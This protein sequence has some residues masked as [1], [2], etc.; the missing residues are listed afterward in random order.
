MITNIKIKYSINHFLFSE[1]LRRKKKIMYISSD[2]LLLIFSIASFVS[3][4][5][6]VIIFSFTTNAL[7]YVGFALLFIAVVLILI[8]IYR[9][10]K[11]KHKKNGMI[12]GV[13]N[14]RPVHVYANNVQTEDEI[15]DS[16]RRLKNMRNECIRL[17]SAIRART[18]ANSNETIQ[19]LQQT[20]RTLQ[21]R[22]DSYKDSNFIPEEKLKEFKDILQQ[23]RFKVEQLK[24]CQD[25]TN[26]NNN[27]Y[28]SGHTKRQHKTI[29]T[30]LE[31]PP[32]NAINQFHEM[33][34]TKNDNRR[35]PEY[36]HQHHDNRRR[37]EHHHQHH[38]NRNQKQSR[39]YL[40]KTLNIL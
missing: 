7:L 37:P 18:N 6:C 4:I 3:A 25:N 22:I 33:H 13:S 11:R 39:Y 34:N 30:N 19:D 16:A 5:V 17:L 21:R 8:Y 15:G 28:I 12:S 29:P 9:R 23:T 10:R 26:R 40:R 1:R 38:D 32:E 35:R 14:Q 2:R 20:L 24:K 27:G 31:N 36:H